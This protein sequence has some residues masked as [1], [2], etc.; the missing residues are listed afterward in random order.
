MEKVQWMR[1]VNTVCQI[2]AI[3]MK[4]N[5]SLLVAVSSV[6]AL[7]S[8]NAYAAT[9][10]DITLSGSVDQDCSVSLAANSFPI[11]L[12]N[13]ETDTTVANVTEVCND[14]D[15]YVVSFSSSNSGVLQNDDNANEQKSYTIS[16][17][18]GSGSIEDQGLTQSRSRS[19]ST[20]TSGNSV[21]LKFDLP[22]HSTG[23]LAAGNWS[24][25]ITVSIAAQ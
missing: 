25:T 8:V 23:V 1:L 20:Y 15:G 4:F 2:E 21:P 10:A 14:A 12:Q 22:A 3:K 13:G 19:Y 16:Y 11:N 17:G 18:S 6:F 24:D 9:S 7:M 5:K